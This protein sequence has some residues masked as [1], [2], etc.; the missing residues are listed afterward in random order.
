MLIWWFNLPLFEKISLHKLNGV[1]M[2]TFEDLKTGLETACDADGAAGIEAVIQINIEDL[3][4]F[5]VDINDGS[6]SV[7]EAEHV[8]THVR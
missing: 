2:A 5:Y 6:L 3:T 7:V 1:N 8:D 4:N